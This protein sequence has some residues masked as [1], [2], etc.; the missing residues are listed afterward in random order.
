MIV[1]K[2]VS[3]VYDSSGATGIEDMIQKSWQNKIQIKPSTFNLIM[4]QVVFAVILRLAA[5]HSWT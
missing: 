1:W 4:M 5:A 3:R 2:Q